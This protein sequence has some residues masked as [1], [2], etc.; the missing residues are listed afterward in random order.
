MLK[1]SMNKRALSMSLFFLLVACGPTPTA[2]P[3]PPVASPS[4][5]DVNT[6]SLMPQSETPT[7]IIE[8]TPTSAGISEPTG[9]FFFQVLSPLD[10]AIV[11]TPQVD[12]IGSALTGAVISV[13]DEILIVG[14][15]QQFRTTVTL[16]EGLNLIEVIAS[17]ESGNEASVLL[18]VTYEP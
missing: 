5:Q 9:S 2:A 7:A 12:V 13:N 15:D 10:D 18:T 16:E 6:A 4:V 8:S 1:I 17:D 3:L 14:A 11:N